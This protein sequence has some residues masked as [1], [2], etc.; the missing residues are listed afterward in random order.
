MIK[1]Q[2]P[3]IPPPEGV[4][5]FYQRLPRTGGRYTGAFCGTDD[6]DDDGYES[7]DILIGWRWAFGCD[8]NAL[9]AEAE[10]RGL[11]TYD[12]PAGPFDS[13]DEAC[14][15]AWTYFSPADEGK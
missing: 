13:I 2:Q 7:F 9:E 3:A 10:E 14:E 5:L 1:K 6:P 15:D 12:D 11:P 8:S 4:S